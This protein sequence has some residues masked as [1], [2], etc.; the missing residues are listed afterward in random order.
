MGFPV[1]YEIGA[2][3]ENLLWSGTMFFTN[4]FGIGLGI[5][6]YILQSLGLYT[7][8]CRRQLKNPWLAWLPIGNM[9][10]L[11]SISDQYQYVT[12]GRIRN[13][14]K[15]LVGLHIAILALTVVWVVVSLGAIIGSIMSMGGMNAMS[16]AQVW[17][18]V[19]TPL[20]TSVGMLLVL[21]V[22]AIIGAVIQYI[23]LYDLYRSCDPKNGV[24]YLLLSIFI[25]NLLAVFVF[26]CREKDGG[27]PPR[28]TGSPFTE[29]QP[30]QGP[31]F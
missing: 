25:S 18:M 31:E 7:I 10:I 23:A 21:W 22:V 8:A 12:T 5:V 17:E 4:F 19:V 26:L 2:A 29:D 16:E 15:T 24:L 14:R 6:M 27:M 30:A 13:R 3:L 11:G 20:L 28:R 9:W 1:G